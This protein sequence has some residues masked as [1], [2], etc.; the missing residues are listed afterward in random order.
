LQRVAYVNALG[1]VELVFS[2]IVGALIFG[3]R[4]SL[5]EWQGLALLTGSIGLLVLL[6]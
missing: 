5:R 1:Q 3:E 2:L 6:A 4:I